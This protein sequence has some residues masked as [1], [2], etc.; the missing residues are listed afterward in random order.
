[1][2][3]IEIEEPDVNEKTGKMFLKSQ[4]NEELNYGK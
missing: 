4:I 3:K 2:K 1:M